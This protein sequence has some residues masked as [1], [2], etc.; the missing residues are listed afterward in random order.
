MATIIIDKLTESKWSFTTTDLYD[1]LILPE[2]EGVAT[3]GQ[4]ITCYGDTTLADFDMDLENY[5][6][7]VNRNGGKISIGGNYGDQKSYR[8]I[9]V[10][11]GLYYGGGWKDSFSGTFYQD[12]AGNGR[13]LDSYNIFHVSY[14]SDD[15][16]G[17]IKFGGSD[18]KL[19]LTAQLGAGNARFYTSAANNDGDRQKVDDGIRLRSEAYGLFSQYDTW[20]SQLIYKKGTNPATTSAKTISHT[21]YA[22][23]DLTVVSDLAGEIE[24]SAAALHGGYYYD[25]GSSA[26]YDN[27]STGREVYATGVKAADLTLGSNFRAVITAE[28]N[29]DVFNFGMENA[30]FYDSQDIPGKR[31]QTLYV[32]AESGTGESGTGGTDEPGADEP[33]TGEPGGLPDVPGEPVEPGPSLEGVNSA[34]AVLTGKKWAEANGYDYEDL[35]YTGFNHYLETWG[36]SLIGGGDSSVDAD[37]NK[38]ITAGLWVDKSLSM[39]E[40]TVWAGSITVDNSDVRIIADTD[41]RGLNNSAT[42]MAADAK[43]NEVGSYG[44]RVD[45]TLTIG[46]IDKIIM[47]DNSYDTPVTQNA[48]IT[49]TSLDNFLWASA[50][51]KADA[52]INDS[53]INAA[54]IWTNTLVLGTVTDNVNI[55]VESARNYMGIGHHISVLSSLISGSEVR[56]YGIYAATA[57]LTDFD[58]NIT[59]T[60]TDDT[61]SS[62]AALYITSKLEAAH[63]LNGTF[64]VL[65]CVDSYGIYA[66]T[67]SVKGSINTDIIGHTEDGSV[68]L[69]FG[70]YSSNIT[71]SDFSGSITALTGLN[72]SGKYLSEVAD[73]GDAFDVTGSI[74]GS[75]G[76]LSGGELN[77]RISGEIYATDRAVV[78]DT[79][80]DAAHAT[81]IIQEAKYDDK[82]ELASTA[83]IYG[84]IDLGAGTNIINI[85]SSAELHGAI[86]T[87]FGEVN[88]FFHLEEK[89]ENRATVT[90]GED[91]YYHEDDKTLKDSFTFTVNLNYATVGETYTL[92]EY[93]AGNVAEYWS[94]DRQIAFLYQGCNG[95]LTLDK[96]NLKGEAVIIDTEGKEFGKA[97]AWFENNKVYVK[98]DELSTEKTPAAL[99][100]DYTREDKSWESP[101]AKFISQ[102]YDKDAHT[103][104]LEWNTTGEVLNPKDY[105]LA[106]IAMYEIEYQLFDEDGLEIG[107]SVTVRLDADKATNYTINGVANNTDVKWR[108]RLLG[109]KSANT[110]SAWSEWKDVVGR[111]LTA[112]EIADGGITSTYVAATKSGF[113]N[114][115]DSSVLDANPREGTTGVVAAIAEL[116]WGKYSSSDKTDKKLTPGHMESNFA[117]HHYEIEYAM[118]DKRVTVEEIGEGFT[119]D[120]YI[121]GDFFDK[122]C[123][124]KDITVYR[125]TV[126]GTE[127]AISNLQNQSFVYWRIKA[128]DIAGGESE[129]V[130]GDTFRVW[131]NNDTSAP[132]FTDEVIGNHVEYY[133][134]EN[135]EEPAMLNENTVIGWNAATD[136]E[137][138][139][140]TYIIEISQDGGKTYFERAQVAAEQL[141]K[142]E[143]NGVTYDYTYVLDGLPGPTHHYRVIAVDYF[144]KKSNPIT[145]SFSVDSTSPSFVNE[146]ICGVEDT[147]VDR[148]NVTAVKLNPV[149]KWSKAVDG[150]GELGIRYYAVQIREEGAENWDTIYTTDA[151]LETFTYTYTDNHSEK[152]DAVRYEYRIIAYDHFG[153][154]DVVSGYFGSKDMDAPVGSF[155]KDSSKFT[156]NVNATYVDRYENRTVTKE[157][158]QADGSIKYE[159]V[160]ETVLVGREL[161]NAEVT[162]SWADD[163]TDKSGVIYKVTISEDSFLSSDSKTFSFWT[164][165]DEGAAKTMTFDNSTTGRTSSIFNGMKQVYWM[166][167]A[168]DTNYNAASI[169]SKIY[170]FEFK[171]QYGEYVSNNQAPATPEITSMS[172]KNKEDDNGN[173]RAEISLTWETPNTLLGVYSYTVTLYDSTGKKVLFE[174]NTTD[175]AEYLTTDLSSK[176]KVV[177]NGT[178]NTLTINELHDFFDGTSMLPENSYKAVVTAHDNSGRSTKSEAYDFIVDTTVPSQVEIIEAA[179]VVSNPGG[180][181][182]STLLLR[183]NAIED[184]SGIAYYLVEYCQE[185]LMGDSKNWQSEKITDTEFSIVVG[186]TEPAYV[187]RV[188]AYDKAGNRGIAWSSDEVVRI[189]PAQDNLSDL[190]SNPTSKNKEFMESDR[191]VIGENVDKYGEPYLETVGQGDT[192][193]VFSVDVVNG[194][195]ALSL[196]A[197][198]LSA[199]FGTNQAIKIDIYE[200]SNTSKVWKTYTVKSDSRVFTDLL[201]KNNTTYT[202]KVTN[203]STKTS[204]STYKLVL[205]KTLLGSGVAD[206]GQAKNYTGDDTL[207]LLRLN[208][209]IEKRNTIT[210]T[211]E[212]GAVDTLEDWVGY[213]DTADVRI[214]DVTASGRYSFTL[215]DV[216]ASAK[217]TVYQIVDGKAKS[218]GTVTATQS[219]LDGVATKD[220]ILDANG[221][222]YIEVKATNANA[223]GSDYTVD[224]TCKESY[225]A[226]SD[227]DT[228]DDK[229]DGSK[230]L[231]VG[232]I[233]PDGYVGVTD[234]LDNFKLDGKI[235]GNYQ[236]KLDGIAGKEI[237]VAMGWYD[238]AKDKFNKIVSK[239]GAANTD[240]L[241]L[242]LTDKEF[243][244]AKGDMY[245]Q[246]SANGKTANS[247]YDLS[248]EKNENIA[249]FNT[250]DNT[251]SKNNPLLVAGHSENNWVGLGDDT[252]YYKLALNGSGMYNIAITG[253]EN[254]LKVTL[255]KSV[256]GKMTALKNITL[257]AAAGKDSGMLAN[258][259][260]NGKED[261][262]VAVVGSGARKGQ[263]SDYSIALDTGNTA[264]ELSLLEDVKIIKQLT[265]AGES[266]I[267]TAPETGGA[268]KFTVNADDMY[269]GSLKLTVYELLTTGKTRTVKTITVKAGAEGTTGYL[270]FADTAVKNGTGVY[271]VEVKAANASSGGDC[272][273]KLEGYDFGKYLAGK[274]DPLLFG[275]RDWVGMGDA[276]DAITKELAGVYNLNLTGING[277]N[278]K[279]LIVDKATGK[280]LKT[281]T[282]ATNATNATFGYDFKAGNYEIRVESADGGKAKF[283]EYT[284]ELES[285]AEDIAKSD[286]GFDAKLQVLDRVDNAVEGWVGLND[287]KDY[288]LV[289]V[290][291]TGN[292]NFAINDLSNDVKVV[293]YDA[294]RK[295]YKTLTAKAADNGSV[296]SEVLLEAGKNY[297]VMMQSSATN[298]LKDSEYSLILEQA[299]AFEADV[300]SNDT[301]QDAKTNGALQSDGN[302]WKT[303]GSVMKG[304]DDCD[305]Y[306]IEVTE[307][308]SYTLDLAGINGNTIAAS[309]GTMDAKGNFKSLQKVTGKAGA[310]SLVI[311]RN[312]TAGTYY[313]KVES[314]TKNTASSYDLQLTRNNSLA[315]FSNND[316]T[317]Q[318]TAADVEAET[319]GLGGA[320]ESYLGYGDAAD[321]LKIK[322]SENGVVTFD[323]E[324]ETLKALQAK[325]L[326]LAL[327]D[328][329]GKSVALAFDAESGEYTTKTILMADVEYYLSVKNNKSSQLEMDFSI[330][331]K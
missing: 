274:N 199:V 167:E 239:T 190:V 319:Y 178:Y 32:K 48:T 25:T 314:V 231:A 80:R 122:W 321:V 7:S 56:A 293:L 315:G 86:R 161:T 144:G 305:Y 72:V 61:R 330:A 145:G 214:L 150:A 187:F 166:V 58:G 33:G 183:W 8:Y 158:I 137:S 65:G 218:I 22:V 288:Y 3:A 102:T 138:G 26:G 325:Q 197:E 198:E 79:Y 279:L 13:E 253:A 105:N 24:S 75:Y 229:F 173:L 36:T 262:Y 131:T 30:D 172:I 310:D 2:A 129:W 260:L 20:G 87:G 91:G 140:R 164:T 324:A 291:E 97:S 143:I 57:K 109:D 277:N 130:A 169:K 230:L 98:V 212:A 113:S 54:G 189:T 68:R 19:V 276:S 60:S 258:L 90:I 73:K 84:D 174:K 254:P 92:F 154:T 28:N 155:D 215:K 17:G 238:S 170:S 308:G 302:V 317:W 76:V 18:A 43:N 146:S 248:L 236:L 273:V 135:Y 259:L 275:K 179:S 115:L 139:V 103:L 206:N 331:I 201:L 282:P 12:T 46:V 100:W 216:A 208:E 134:P 121:A 64:T 14:T 9:S 132:V 223:Y 237:T 147:G 327:Y 69:D 211:T 142:K 306:M 271:Q 55:S 240:E 16:S 177:D 296:L 106:T 182:A 252:D 23:K 281:F 29:E 219:K 194:S 221:E 266:M 11:S 297:Y 136:T 63:R 295:Q 289:D 322:I 47:N 85:S 312:L 243:A 192:A 51:G 318:L 255:Y 171:D 202:F 200:G 267:F 316:D 59:V 116:S 107:K 21:I 41:F 156:G 52:Y 195:V 188:V 210:L 303:S 265:Q 232:G 149:F 50:L 323:A 320:V 181:P 268:Y 204:V 328:A 233:V 313:V 5:A 234:A 120:D 326:S 205:D 111:E 278:L 290:D 180:T 269:V 228:A 74:I 284:L 257:T 1:M 250:G 117:V 67:I 292:Y 307:D 270:Y 300:Q 329:N 88:I 114:Q 299:W 38:V 191:M 311:Q 34:F 286:N 272:T 83:L 4:V 245:I 66:P 35:R 112:Q 153:L 70:I 53:K 185:P 220:M 99:V 163:Y 225:P 213:G 119:L 157:I 235:S 125:K 110:V 264:E 49:V 148:T 309:L 31:K 227:A 209:D 244:K 283:S 40:N 246:V 128:V 94:H 249:G 101:T 124:E 263:N 196:T 93:A 298:G 15:I 78:T 127:I 304:V 123:K 294:N 108:M 37:N 162:L 203:S 27:D 45:G 10:Y 222:Y 104:K 160:T 256:N 6:L 287:A 168:Y 175:L 186:S 301:I 95:T 217:L 71:A 207:A 151:Q 224:I 118:V 176:V 261:Y 81:W 285:R 39:A 193:D 133:I 247:L 42:D 44:I 241:I 165:T 126:S 184:A 89:A 82:L 62:A 77:L 226:A 242:S 141:E 280:T 251:V 96:N 159:T 152:L